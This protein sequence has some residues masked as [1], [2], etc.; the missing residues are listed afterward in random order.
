METVSAK[1][2][3]LTTCSARP[4]PAGCNATVPL[5]AL[6]LGHNLPQKL[7]AAEITGFRVGALA[8][9]RRSCG[10]IELQYRCV[11]SCV[12]TES[13]VVNQSPRQPQQCLT[14]QYRQCESIFSFPTSQRQSLLY[15]IVKQSLVALLRLSETNL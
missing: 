2:S 3:T 14:V 5:I 9:E 11:T 7:A 6:H 12:S 4:K 1:K 13:L 10:V 8:G 15:P